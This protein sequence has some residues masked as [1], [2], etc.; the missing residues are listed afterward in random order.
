MC[1]SLSIWKLPVTVIVYTRRCD[2]A[3]S[4]IKFTTIALHI[5]RYKDKDLNKDISFH[6]V[7][8]LTVK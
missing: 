1:N 3:M 8:N 6:R 7:I 4:R 5:R 2:Y